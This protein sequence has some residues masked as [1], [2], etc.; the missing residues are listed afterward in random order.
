M[1]QTVT[2]P[3]DTLKTLVMTA[4]GQGGGAGAAG[5]GAGAG[6]AAG[7]RGGASGTLAVL[8][9][10]L[11]RSGPAGL[12]RG[13]WPAMARQGPV[14]VGRCRLPVSKPEFTA[15]VVSALE[16]II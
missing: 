8:R 4:G 2:Q 13:Y 11:A 5:A 7:A 16:T 10:L 1:A 15:L 3:A 9:Q 6:T 12:Y 14:M